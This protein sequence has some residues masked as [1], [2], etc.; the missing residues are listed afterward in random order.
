MKGNSGYVNPQT[1]VNLLLE[2][3]VKI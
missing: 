1:I 3:H 2:L